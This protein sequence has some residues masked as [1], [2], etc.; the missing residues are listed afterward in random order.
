MT[1]S[2]RDL[3]TLDPQTVVDCAWRVLA[4]GPAMWEASCELWDLADAVM[5]A[6]AKAQ[7]AA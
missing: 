7:G 5:E 4:M 2:D 1:A 6:Q 3:L